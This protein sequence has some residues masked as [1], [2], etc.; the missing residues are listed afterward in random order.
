MQVN[1]SRSRRKR[2]KRSSKKAEKLLEARSSRKEEIS[3]RK[4]VISNKRE[5]RIRVAL[6]KRELPAIFMTSQKSILG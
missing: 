3:S 1:Y 5:T 2:R 4:E 6:L